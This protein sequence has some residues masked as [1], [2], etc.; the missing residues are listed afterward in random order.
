MQL[1]KNK[2]YRIIELYQRFNNGEVMSKK[3]ISY[4]YG[5]DLRTVQRY[6]KELND[7]FE[8]HDKNKNEPIRKIKYNSQRSVYELVN[9]NSESS[10][11]EG[12]ILAICKIILD[13]RAFSTVFAPVE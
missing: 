4:E 5:V 13:S 2:I 7:F 1:E 10:L 12:D 6:I 9:R 11:S 3:K 8:E